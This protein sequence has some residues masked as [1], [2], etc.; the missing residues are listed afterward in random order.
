M[1]IPLRNGAGVPVML[2]KPHYTDALKRLISFLT[3]KLPDVVKKVKFVSS[4]HL[5][6]EVYY[7]IFLSL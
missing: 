2:R 7:L 4:A 5:N 3:P 1:V 6:K